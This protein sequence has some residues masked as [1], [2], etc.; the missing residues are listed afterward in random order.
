MRRFLARQIR[1]ARSNK[2]PENFGLLV[3]FKD[4][5]A[6]LAC[7]IRRETSI[8][9]RFKLGRHTRERFSLTYGSVASG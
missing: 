1:Q 9:A 5:S 2:L 7:S 4:A 3:R 6:L 8:G